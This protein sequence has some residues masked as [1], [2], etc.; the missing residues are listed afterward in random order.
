MTAQSASRELKHYGSLIEGYWEEKQCLFF[1]DEMSS[2][3]F[4]VTEKSD[5]R[6]Q[7]PPWGSSKISNVGLRSH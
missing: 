1:I 2:K 7:P 3:A 4:I 6:S 5:V